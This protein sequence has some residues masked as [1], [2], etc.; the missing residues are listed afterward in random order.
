MGTKSETIPPS[1]KRNVHTNRDTAK[2]GLIR[3]MKVRILTGGD[4]KE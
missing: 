2:G 1:N 3:N 4:E